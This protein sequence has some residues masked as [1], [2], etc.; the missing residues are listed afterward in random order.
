MQFIVTGRDG[1]DPDALK[2]RMSARP[3]HLRMGDEMKRRGELLFAAAILDDERKMIGSLCVVDFEDKAK[4][5]EWL[6]IEPYVTGH[7]WQKL[8]VRMCQVGPSFIS[9]NL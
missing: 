3:D 4:L 7:V 2:R 1:S 6:K 9:K 5:D 8:E